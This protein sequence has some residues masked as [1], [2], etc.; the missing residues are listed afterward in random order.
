MGAVNEVDADLTALCATSLPGGSCRVAVWGPKGGGTRTSTAAAILS[1]LDGRLVGMLAGVD[2]NPDLRNL[3]Q[4]LGLGPSKVPGRLQ[5]LAQDPSVIRYLADWAAYLDRVGRIHLLHND[6]VPGSAVHRLTEPQYRAVFDLLARYAEVQVIDLGQSPFHPASRAAL[7][8]ADHLVVALPADSAVLRLAADA[9]DELAAAGHGKLL[10]RATVVLTVTQQRVKPAAYQPA[11]DWLTGRVG[12]VQVV[13]FDRRVGAGY[14][15]TDT[16]KLAPKTVLAYR[17]VTR[18]V[19]A[20]VRTGA[21]PDSPGAIPAESPGQHATPSGRVLAWQPTWTTPP[22]VTTRRAPADAAPLPA[23][24]IA[25]APAP[26]AAR[27]P[28]PPL[29]AWASRAPEPADPS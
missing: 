1:V 10:G 13:P 18:H 6:N 20:T 8:T 3:T 4:R 2:A 29:P 11:V 27:E 28:L 14:D 19:L 21:G 5:T 23:P 16:S 26:P 25:L 22:A 12:H 17:A 15:H 7:E 9:L 24:D